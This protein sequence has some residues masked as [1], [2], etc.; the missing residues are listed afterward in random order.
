MKSGP[1]WKLHLKL[2][3]CADHRIISTSE[4]ATEL[5]NTAGAKD[6]GRSGSRLFWTEVG[7]QK[8]WLQTNPWWHG[9]VCPWKVLK[10]VE[11]GDCNHSCPLFDTITSRFALAILLGIRTRCRLWPTSD[12]NLGSA[13]DR[14]P[15]SEHLQGVHE[16]AARC[17][18]TWKRK[19]KSRTGWW[20]TY[21][22]E[23]Y[24]SQ[25]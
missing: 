8:P 11:L 20:L 21:P 7:P 24:E 22:Y 18:E 1:L 9:S 5:T 23:K 16:V 15:A 19:D 12:A 2:W 6:Q 13:K 17:S 25:F 4:V 3:P 14:T 10:Y